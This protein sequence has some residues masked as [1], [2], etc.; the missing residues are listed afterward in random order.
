MQTY[1]DTTWIKDEDV[2]K[3]ESETKAKINAAVTD[4]IKEEEEDD[5]ESENEDAKSKRSDSPGNTSLI[6]SVKDQAAEGDGME[7]TF[8]SLD[9]AL[10]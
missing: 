5:A 9:E 10:E 2:D 7:D 3:K 6:G 8:M 4:E 1:D